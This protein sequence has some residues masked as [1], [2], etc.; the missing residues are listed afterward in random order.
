MTVSRS[1]VPR[2]RTPRSMLA[3]FACV[4]LMLLPGSAAALQFGS[5]RCSAYNVSGIGGASCRLTPPIVINPDGSYQESSTQGTYKVS[6]NRIDFSESTVRGPGMIMGQNQSIFHTQI[7]F[8]YDYLQRRH[9]VTYL[10]EDCNLPDVK[11][12]AS[13]TA[14][15]GAPPVR[16]EVRLHFARADGFLDWATRAYL[17]PREH[18]GAFAASP[19]RPSSPPPGAVQGSAGR[20]GPQ[21]VDTSFKRAHVEVDYVVF[22]Q[23]FSQRIAVASLRLPKAPAAQPLTVSASFDHSLR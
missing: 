22:L 19:L 20:S 1:V 3:P 23:S 13:G 16:A 9:T 11:H 8:E 6:G 7:I 14:A 17:I 4:A 10:C 2:G 18:A 21:T 5:Y 15:A 12:G